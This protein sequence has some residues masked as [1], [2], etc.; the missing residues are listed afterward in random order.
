MLEFA[1]PEHP[2]T[3]EI[4]CP[5]VY[6]S[7]SCTGPAPAGKPLEIHFLDNISYIRGNHAFKSGA[8]CAPTTSTSSAAPAIPSGSIRRS[9]SAGWTRRSAAP[10]RA[11][12]G[13]PTAACANLTGSGINATDSNNLQTLY[14]MMLGRVGRIDQVFYSAGSS[15]CR[16][17]P[18]TLKQRLQEYNFY[19]QDDW[20]ITPKLTLNAGVRYELNTVPYDA[21]GVQVVAD[22]PLDG[23]QGPVTF[24]QGGPGTGRSWFK[25]DKN[26]VAP[27]V[28]L[29]YDVKGDGKLEM[30]G[31]YRIAYQRLVSWALNVVEQRQPATSLNQFLLGPAA[32]R[33]AAPTPSSGSTR[34]SRAAVYP[35]PRAASRSCRRTASRT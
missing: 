28:G 32:P 9:P 19:L 18:L 11:R 26:N 31:S 1:D 22:R 2:K 14:N 29:A 3:Y 6:D 30:S 24:L 7:A 17:Q 12:C 10:T 34:C 20:R 25:M 27:V 5:C 33:S 4:R 35:T 23:S 8:R 16:S 21:S 15:T 13:G